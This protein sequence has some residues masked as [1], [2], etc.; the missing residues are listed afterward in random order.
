M[1][2]FKKRKDKEITEPTQDIYRKF[3][4]EREEALNI[5]DGEYALDDDIAEEIFMFMWR[6]IQ[7]MK[8]T[9][10]VASYLKQVE[11]PMNEVK[12]AYS[13]DDEYINNITS[14][15]VPK[16]RVEANKMI[17]DTIPNLTDP[18]GWNNGPG[19]IITYS[20]F[21]ERIEY[22]FEVNRN[23][24]KIRKEITNVSLISNTINNPSILM[25]L[26]SFSVK[27]TFIIAKNLGL[28]DETMVDILN[29]MYISNEEDFNKLLNST[30]MEYIIELLTERINKLNNIEPNTSYLDY[31][32]L[33]FE[34]EELLESINDTKKYCSKY[35]K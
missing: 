29:Q 8:D 2:R 3:L 27:E 5:F 15:I 11:I 22:I 9:I 28:V 33:S 26:N 12:R 16:L 6:N 25:L 18:F 35:N 32:E 1:F 24:K 10:I 20:E 31:E 14:N 4:A 17:T 13:L 19:L 30:R 21:V 23:Q 7:N 34:Y